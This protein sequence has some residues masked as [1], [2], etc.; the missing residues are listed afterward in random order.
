MDALQ[1]SGL[2]GGRVADVD[3]DP[4][5]DGSPNTGICPEGMLLSCTGT[6]A[7]GSGASGMDDAFPAEFGT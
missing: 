3:G 4:A 1:A 2:N 6:G 7:A 5:Y